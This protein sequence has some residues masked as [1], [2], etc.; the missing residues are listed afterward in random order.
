MEKQTLKLSN[1]LSDITFQK[2]PTEVIIKSKQLL[3]DY[4]G[5]TLFA[6]KEEKAAEIIIK[7]IK[8]LGV[9][10]ESTVLGYGIKTSCLLAAF[11]NGAMG[12]MTEL[13]DTHTG[14]SSHPG[15]SI[16]SAA[17]A[18]GE[19]EGIS[20]KELLVSIISGYEA[21]LRIGESVMPTH[22]WRGFHPSATIN[23]FGAAVSGGKILNF[24][25]EQIANTLGLAG[26]QVSGYFYYLAE[27]IRMP[28]DF[29]TGRAAMSGIFAAVLT[30]NGFQGGRTVLESENGFCKL[31]SD[32]FSV[33][34]DRISDRVGQVF[35]ILE[36]AHKPYTGC[37]HLHSAVEATLNI[38][39]K[40]TINPY[41]V[42]KINAIIFE[43][44]AKF[45]N[46]P[47]P[48]LPDRAG[49]GN[50]FSTQFNVAV[51]LLE[52][53]EGIHNLLNHK[54]VKEKMNDLKVRDFMKKIQV[55]SDP[56][57]D[58]EYPKA[59]P[60]II[61]IINKKGKKYRERVDLPKGEPQNPLTQKELENKFI[62]LAGNVLTSKVI[63]KVIKIVNNIEKFDSIKP[64]IRMLSRK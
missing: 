43:T 53:S 57:L 44:G 19:R 31:F 29:N 7:T 28:K 6:Y 62:K 24:N 30:K 20:G 36:V 12:H 52:G 61:E 13:D 55:I 2:I 32:P 11:A 35:K 46:D 3:L 37:R 56:D 1:G 18:L 64:L 22:Y 38:L 48:W 50:R 16:I 25:S 39:G 26:L 54:Y 51:A 5:Y 60:T 41:N 40:H 42:E 59:W 8:E 14:T 9:N 33:R 49:Y 17:L 21:A 27:N 58:K 47:E 4:L 10:C 23:T 45:V 63:N 15:D 34:F